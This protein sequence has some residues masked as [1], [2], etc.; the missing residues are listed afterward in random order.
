MIPVVN[1]LYSLSNALNRGVKLRIRKPFSKAVDNS[2]FG[3]V[4]LPAWAKSHL[5]AWLYK[6]NMG[7]LR[8]IHTPLFQH[9]I[10]ENYQ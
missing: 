7:E 4:L 1:P 5:H 6:L 2:L 9:R 8:Y 10:I 3:K